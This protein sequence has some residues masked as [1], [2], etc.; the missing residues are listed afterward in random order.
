M[1]ATEYL[2]TPTEFKF[3]VDKMDPR[4]PTIV[5]AMNTI[6]R[7]VACLGDELTTVAGEYGMRDW[8]THWP[9]EWTERMA[10]IQAAC[11]HFVDG[12]HQQVIDAFE[13]SDFR[14]IDND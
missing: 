12:H 9:C 5:T 1:N 6:T 7:A 3:Y 4:D 8:Y 11:R 13:D 10:R 14:R 2:P